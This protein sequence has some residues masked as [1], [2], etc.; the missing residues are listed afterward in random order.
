MGF[1]CRLTFQVLFLFFPAVSFGQYNS[2]EG[3]PQLYG[4]V[5]DTV[6]LTDHYVYGLSGDFK[7]ILSEQQEEGRI[8]KTDTIVKQRK[9]K[10][11]TRKK[12][13]KE[14]IIEQQTDG[15]GSPCALLFYKRRHELIN[16]KWC[17]V[18]SIAYRLS[19]SDGFRSNLACTRFDSETDSTQCL[20]FL[21]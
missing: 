15:S 21:V 9:N 3:Y 8:M 4:N 10:A 17:V 11:E 1:L 19:F 20:Q 7:Y 14:Q 5:N 12:N 13:R 18:H 6:F 2:F 16:D